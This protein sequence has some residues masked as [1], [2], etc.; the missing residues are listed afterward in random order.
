MT[1]L[2]LTPLRVT[3]L[4]AAPCWLG[5]SWGVR[6]GVLEEGLGG[7]LESGVRGSHL[8]LGSGRIPQFTGGGSCTE[9]RFYIRE[10]VVCGWHSRNEM[11][12]ECFKKRYRM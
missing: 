6:E 1:P 8:L 11:P 10:R 5:S 2:E 7:I 4:G 3:P 12:E 9:I